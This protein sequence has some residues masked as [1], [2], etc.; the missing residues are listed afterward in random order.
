MRAHNS[1]N[2]WIRIWLRH[3]SYRNLGI[4]RVVYPCLLTIP[5]LE[6]IGSRW[7][8]SLNPDEERL[9]F[10]V[11]WEIDAA[12]NITNEWFGRSVIKSCV[13]LSYEHAQVNI[14]LPGSLVSIAQPLIQYLRVRQGFIDKP[15]QVWT[16]EELPAITCGYS[17]NDIKKRVLV[18]NKVFE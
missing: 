2:I 15:D 3:S 8:C 4:Q 17:V 7:S 13:K 12:G 5:P 10:S 14:S 9:A 16:E 18:L 6:F 1:R 11:L